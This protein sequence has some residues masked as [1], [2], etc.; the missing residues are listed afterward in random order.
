[1]KNSSRF[2]WFSWDL[3]ESLLGLRVHVG[4][5]CGVREFEST[6]LR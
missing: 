2:L 5:S 4:V 1:M 3:G 6:W